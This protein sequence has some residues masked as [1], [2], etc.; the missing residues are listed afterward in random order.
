MKAVGVYFR[1]G[2]RRSHAASPRADQ[3]YG[4]AVYAQFRGSPAVRGRALYSGDIL[5]LDYIVEHPVK[6]A[7]DA[8][9]SVPYSARRV[10]AYF[11]VSASQPRR[12]DGPGPE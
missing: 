7:R 11:G 1:H 2:P 8:A 6:G 3:V 12:I 5:G 4:D 10:V 9:N